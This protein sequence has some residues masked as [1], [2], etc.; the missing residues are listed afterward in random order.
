MAKSKLAKANEKIEKKVVGGYKK[1][2]E[3]V[4][5]GFNKVADKFVDS[6]LTKEGESVEEARE[7]LAAE[8][9]A[10]EA[11][12]VAEAEK[13]SQ[14]QNTIV[15]KSLQNAQNASMEA[16]KKAGLDK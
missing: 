7:R 14:E 3:G 15:E 12:G 11:A 9:K 4:V 6:F 16:R 13:R 8:Q 2:E 10:R 1:I 5:G